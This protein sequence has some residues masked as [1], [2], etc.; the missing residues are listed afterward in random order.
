M[1]NQYGGLMVM[2]A[3]AAAAALAAVFL[4]PRLHEARAARAQV[5]YEQMKQVSNKLPIAVLSVVGEIEYLA[6]NETEWRRVTMDTVLFEGVTI[7]SRAGA[8]L[9][10]QAVGVFTAEIGG[11]ANVAIR[12]ASSGAAGEARAVS[13]VVNAGEILVHADET[14]SAR[15]TVENAA[16]EKMYMERGSAMSSGGAGG[17]FL[18]LTGTAEVSGVR[19]ERRA[20]VSESA[21]PAAAGGGTA[22]KPKGSE[23]AETDADARERADR[24]Q[25]LKGLLAA[26]LKPQQRRG[27]EGAQDK[28]QEI[29]LKWIRDGGDDLM[30]HDLAAAVDRTVDPFVVND[31]KRQREDLMREYGPQFHSYKEIKIELDEDK[32]F[33][34]DMMPG[35]E[36]GV[37]SFSARVTVTRSNEAGDKVVPQQRLFQVGLKVRKVEEKWKAVGISWSQ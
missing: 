33:A 13:L 15:I 4:G 30:K 34:F 25:A 6:E 35:G 7:R 17:R 16:G 22:A 32:K 14:S 9:Q 31:E 20:Y 3:L 21:A 10:I 36:G 8:R 12:S 26:R 5:E 28:D 11:D 24:L 1:S 23:G 2:L 18:M 19:G 29:V 37:V 27:V